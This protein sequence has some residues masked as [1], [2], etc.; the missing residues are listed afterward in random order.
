MIGEK[1]GCVTTEKALEVPKTV[2]GSLKGF[3]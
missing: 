3:M 2:F 1:N